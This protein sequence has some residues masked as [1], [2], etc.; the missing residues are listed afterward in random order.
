M[1]YSQ[2]PLFL[3]PNQL[4]NLRYQSHT[5]SHFLRDLLICWT[6][7]RRD[8]SQIVGYANN[9]VHLS[10]TTRVANILYINVHGYHG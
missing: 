10:P 5:F 8:E 7:S 9:Q 3:Q 2:R 1:V 6:V 4:N